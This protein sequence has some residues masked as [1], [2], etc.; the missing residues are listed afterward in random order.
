MVLTVTTLPILSGYSSVSSIPIEIKRGV[1]TSIAN[2]DESDLQTI[3]NLYGKANIVEVLADNHSLSFSETGDAY[4]PTTWQYYEIEDIDLVNN[5]R[6]TKLIKESI[7]VWLDTINEYTQTITLLESVDVVLSDSDFIKIDE[8]LYRLTT[9]RIPVFIKDLREVT[10]FTNRL[11][12]EYQ[13]ADDIETADELQELTN[14]VLLERLR[15]ISHYALEG[16][17]G[18]TSLSTKSDAEPDIFPDM[19]NT[20]V[21]LSGVSVVLMVAFFTKKKKEIE[22]EEAEE[23][24]LGII[25]IDEDL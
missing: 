16:D 1:E 15:N 9:Y 19:I 2:V 14:G 10:E 11:A 21:V 24:E 3:N 20:L 4:G 17:G 5:E 23:K 7:S 18:L 13:R 22:K 12:R 6:K 8:Y 25:D